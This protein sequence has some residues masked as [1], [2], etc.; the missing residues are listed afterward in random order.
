M[1]SPTMT[2]H[3]VARVRTS[4]SAILAAFNAAFDTKFCVD[5]LDA[6]DSLIGIAFLERDLAVVTVVGS[7]YECV[8]EMDCNDIWTLSRIDSFAQIKTSSPTWRN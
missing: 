7:P 1:C 3:G 8:Y 4:R 5:D 2:H 6:R